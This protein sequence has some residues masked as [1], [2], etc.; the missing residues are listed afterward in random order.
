MFFRNKARRRPHTTPV[1]AQTLESRALM[2]ATVGVSN[3]TLTITGTAGNDSVT[4][5]S[6]GSYTR[7]LTSGNTMYFPSSQIRSV[8]VNLGAGNDSFSLR[9]GN[10][11]FDRVSINMGTGS[12]EALHVETN[13][14]KTLIVDGRSTTT[15]AVVYGT[16]VTTL[17]GTFGV[18]ADRLQMVNGTVVDRIDVDLGRGNDYVSL[19]G[20]SG[21]RSGQ[22]NLGDGDDSVVQARASRFDTTIYGGP[23]FDKFQGYRSDAGVRLNSFESIFWN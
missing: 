7:V 2:S 12:S 3:K 18:G 13:L 8:V 5:N 10:K 16:A 14:V 17:Q 9:H 23:G 19:T 22:I 11:Q 6:Y 20:Y 21:V 4:V 1:A 15:R